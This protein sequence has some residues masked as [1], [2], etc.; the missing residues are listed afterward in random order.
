MCTFLPGLIGCGPSPNVSAV[1]PGSTQN[2]QQPQRIVSTTPSCTELLFSLDLG[3]RVIGTSRFCLFPKEARNRPKV[4]G[5]LD[6][7]DEAILRL[8]PDLVLELEENTDSCNQLRHFGIEVLTVNHKSIDG[9]LES[10]LT[11]GNRFG[12]E[13]QLRAQLL[14]NQIVQ[15]LSNIQTKTADKQP[16]RV[17]IVLGREKNAG[18]LLSIM[19]AGNNPFFAKAIELAGGTNVAGSAPIP[20]PTITPEEILRMNPDVII[21]IGSRITG[22]EAGETQSAIDEQNRKDWNQLGNGVNAVRNNRVHVISD[23]YTYIP[24]PRFILLIKRFAELLHPE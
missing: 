13:T 21:D 12:G 7:D 5:L 20:F 8:N 15:D 6:R 18:Q 9:I 1:L 16:T 11:V 14:H 2:N 22:E 3:D 10:F 23:D 4:G 24:G 17:L 19:V